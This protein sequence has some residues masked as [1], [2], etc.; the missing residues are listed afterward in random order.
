MP[1]FYLIHRLLIDPV[2]PATMIAGTS[3]GV[4]RTTDDWATW[5]ETL[6]NDCLRHMEF[7]TSDSNTIYGTTSGNYCGGLNSGALYFRSLNNG[8]TWTQLT[9]P[10][11]S[12]HE[13]IAIGVTPA[14]PNEVFFL[15]AYN[16]PSGGNDFN[17]L[18]RS[19]NSGSTFTEINP[20]HEPALGSQQ[21]YDWSFTVDPNDED[22][23]FAGGVHLERSTNGGNTWT[24]ITNNGDNVHVDHHFAK[25][26][27]NT[28]WIGSDGGI[29]SSTNNGAA[30]T[31]HN[32]GLAITQYYRMSNAE[33][34][35]G[36]ILAGAQDNGSHQLK[37]NNWIYEFG[38][39]GMDNAIDPND[40]NN[41]KC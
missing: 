17:G 2:N 23:M 27:G 38:G 11:G 1:Y 32:D 13:R 14:A 6:A 12:N 24:R 41:N 21:W 37:N 31:N 18:Y 39:D 28:L 10:N 9:I 35:A 16:D 30:F 26:Y 3:A 34:D 8:Q 15:A 5:T 33:T 4:F 40:K 7:K 29:W 22:I 20:S 25:F 36:I 19:T